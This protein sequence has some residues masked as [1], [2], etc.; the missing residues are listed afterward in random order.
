MFVINVELCEVTPIWDYRTQPV[1]RQTD[2]QQHDDPGGRLH[3]QGLRLPAGRR[4]RGRHH[5]DQQVLQGGLDQEQFGG[6]ED[7]PRGSQEGGGGGGGGGLP[8]AQRGGQTGLP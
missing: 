6:Q 8:L 5:R 2:P 7:L 4:Q 3:H 1:S